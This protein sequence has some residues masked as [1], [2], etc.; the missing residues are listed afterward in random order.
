MKTEIKDFERKEIFEHYNNK[1]NPYLY[2][3]TK[4]DKCYTENFGDTPPIADV[5]LDNK[6]L[7]AKAQRKKE[8]MLERQVKILESKLERVSQS[9]SID[10]QTEEAA[11]EL[12]ESNTEATTEPTLNYD[13]VLQ[14]KPEKVSQIKSEIIN[15][16]KCIIIP[17]DE[18]EHTAVNGVDN[19][20]K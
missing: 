16:Q 9:A 8:E 6:V 19:L 12:D 7:A 20:I 3:T 1:N 2:I 18:N 15:G 10:S 11:I 17:I 4:I 5:L 13:I 14:V